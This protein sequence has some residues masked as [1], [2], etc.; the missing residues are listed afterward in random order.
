M[1]GYPA[2]VICYHIRGLAFAN[3]IVVLANHTIFAFVKN[4][5][6]AFAAA[7]TFYTAGHTA[8]EL[9]KQSSLW[10]ANA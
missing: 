9:N 4:T 10:I 3:T 5:I 1:A 2:V 6:V 8:I 7:R